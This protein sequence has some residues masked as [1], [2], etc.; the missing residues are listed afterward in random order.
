M[1]RK[2][3]LILAATLVLLAGGLAAV[4]AVVDWNSYKPRIAARIED[5]LGRRLTIDGPLSLS[6]L[7][8]PAFTAKGVHLANPD[9]ADPTDMAVLPE[10][11]VR[12]HFWPLLAGHLEIA[13]LDLIEPRITL[14]TF[15]DGSANWQFS[16]NSAIAA[17]AIPPLPGQASAPSHVA[18]APHIDSI[19]VENGVISYRR[20]G[21]ELL[22]FDAV[23]GSLTGLGGSGPLHAAGAARSGGAAFSFDATAGYGEVGQPLPATL[24]MKLDDADL[25]LGGQWVSAGPDSRFNG[26]LTI[27]APDLPGLAR[28]FAARRLAGLL[29]AGPG[30]LEAAVAANPRQIEVRGLTLTAGGL[31]AGG[32]ASLALDGTHHVDIGLAFG[33]L[34]LTRWGDGK[35]ATAAAVPLPSSAGSPPDGRPSAAAPPLAM[36][37]PI[38]QWLSANVDLAADVVTWRGTIL[39]SAHFNAMLSDGG[40][41][42]NDAAVTLPGNSEVNVLGKLGLSGGQPVFEGSFQTASDDLRSLLGWFGLDVDGVPADR[43]HVLRAAGQIKAAGDEIGIA[44]VHLQVD[45][46]HMDA[47]ANLRLGARPA[48]AASFAVDALNADAYWPA[49]KAPAPAVIPPA[50]AAVAAVPP[51]AK[52]NWYDGIDANITG[53]L[54]QLVWKGAT[55]QDLAVDGSWIDGLLTVHQLSAGDISGAQLQLSGGIAGLATAAVPLRLQGV[56]YELHS[57]EPGRLLQQFGVT[58]PVDLDGLGALALSGTLDG[59]TD[60]VTVETRAEAAGGLL[61]I[62]GK[63]D[64]PL[65]APRLDLTV[66]ASHS[67]LTQ[68]VRLFTPGYRPA[69][70]LGAFAL[71]TKLTGDIAQAQLTDLR[72]KA[73]PVTAAGEAHLTWL[74]R[75]RLEASLSADQV[76]VALFLQSGRQGD[77]QPTLRDMIRTGLLIPSPRGRVARGASLSEPP[78]VTAAPRPLVRV[79][80]IADQWSREP[81]DLSWLKSFDAALKLDARA[82]TI[83]ATRL[84]AVGLGIDLADGVATVK[85]LSAQLYG[86]TVAGGGMLNADGAASMQLSLS[87]AQARDALLGMAGLD[88][89]EGV[90]DGDAVFTTSGHSAAEMIG[91]LTGGGKVA[92]R[93]G[94]LRGFDLQAADRR[95]QRVKGPAGLLALVQAGLN[96]GNTHFSS[97]SASFRGDNGVVRSDDLQLTADGGGAKGA[98]Q[99]NLPTRMIDAHADFHL[100]SAPDAPPLVMRMAGPLESP[101]RFVDINAIQTWLAR[102]SP[103]KGRKPKDLLKEVL[104]GLGH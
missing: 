13:S 62:A 80:A 85:G 97:L 44:K 88:I 16:R 89:A 42:L 6:L 101:R 5:G 84:D 47:A 4:P 58:P 69:G 68:L 46:S 76:P 36:I 40:L 49:G 41:T 79:A 102:R 78:Q 17:G 74:G 43:L 14:E 30:S 73:G 87:H 9:G 70:A 19:A 66:E 104:H 27:T 45:A 57:K 56:H 81:V 90:M 77:A 52:A 64:Q 25:R 54:G 100:A 103:V 11:R 32:T 67:S 28:V 92:V 15:A 10:L 98:A 51:T 75:P 35:E 53:R 60:E 72:I 22:R 59:G 8:G 23:S 39:R 24:T 21:A 29:P 33:R 1:T 61:A 71:S 82:V 86:G 7:P 83:G 37:P 99:I 18:S 38:P 91:R 3:G 96:G 12:L 50:P 2:L 34:D 31:Q 93:D 63:I 55:I 48:I 95:L 20:S 65:A 26:K 94:I